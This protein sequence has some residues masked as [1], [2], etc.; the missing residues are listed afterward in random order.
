[1]M[2]VVPRANTSEQ[3]A[4]ASGAPYT[5]QD[6]VARAREEYA[7][8]S[9][10]SE[11]KQRRREWK[12]KR[13]QERWERKHEYYEAKHPPFFPPF[14][15]L[16]TAA[17]SVAWIVGLVQLIKHGAVFGLAIPSTL[18]IWVAILIWMCVYSFVMWPIKAARWHAYYSS[19]DNGKYYYHHHNGFFESIAWLAF[20]AV[21]FWVLWQYVPSTHPYFNQASL[22]WQHVWAH[23]KH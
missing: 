19:G 18:P 7:K 9:D 11:W 4:A 8:L 17:M 10:R 1:M 16:I 2:I 23:L 21:M 15:G 6:Y 13:R 14:L 20:V 22:W 12:N 5:A 3:K